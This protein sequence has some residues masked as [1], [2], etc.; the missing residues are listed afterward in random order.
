MK[1]EF[2]FVK[3]PDH[4]R[5]AIGKPDEGTRMYRQYGKTDEM[6]TWFDAVDEICEPEGSISPGGVCG[7]VDVSRAGVHKRLKE[8]RLSGFLYHVIKDSKFFKNKKTFGDEGRMPYVFI[9]VSECKAWRVDLER[10]ASEEERKR[11][12]MGDY[13]WDG[14]VLKSPPLRKWQRKVKEEGK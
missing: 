2:P 9:P 12:M 3:I 13:D 5:D 6:H 8:G 10:N 14:Q 7:Y 1:T 4:L 11:A